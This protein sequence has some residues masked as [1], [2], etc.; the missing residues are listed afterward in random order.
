MR[1]KNAS[2]QQT[3]KNENCGKF[4]EKSH[5]AEKTVA[6]FPQLLKKFSSVQLDQK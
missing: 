6:F 5:S 1:V 3:S 2:S 4:L